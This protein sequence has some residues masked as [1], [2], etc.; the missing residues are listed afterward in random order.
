MGKCR[1]THGFEGSLWPIVRAE[2]G[3]EG[4]CQRA[5]RKQVVWAAWDI[6]T[7]KSPLAAMHTG[8]KAPHSFQEMSLWGNSG[9]GEIHGNT[10]WMCL[11]GLS[12]R[13]KEKDQSWNTSNTDHPRPDTLKDLTDNASLWNPSG[14][15]RWVARRVGVLAGWLQ[16][17]RQEVCAEALRTRKSLGNRGE[18]GK[19]KP[20]LD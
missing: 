1:G 3:Y 11:G 7:I 20:Q 19:G 16:S 8:T 5:P 10:M 18:R 4:K 15:E 14:P 12:D 2:L 6:H 13:G 17:K 9:C